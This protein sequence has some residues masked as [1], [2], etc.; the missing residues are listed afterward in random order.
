MR[1]RKYAFLR[2]FRYAGEGIWAALRT[3]RNLRVHV[4]VALLV[5]CFGWMVGL[6]R[7]EWAAIL[8]TF[9]MVIGLELV[10]TAV[11][12]LVDLASPRYHLLAKL[13]KDSAA[14]GVLVAAAA[15]VGLGLLVFLPALGNFGH[16]FMV[17]WRQS[18]SLVIAVLVVLALGY[19]VLW[20]VVPQKE[21]PEGGQNHF[22]ETH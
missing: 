19:L 21:H 9:G 17:R 3:Q 10:N 5:T 12:A 6:R 22:G 8:V 4:T 11:E 13:A 15:A 18:P 14:G 1:P 20:T 16:D 7:W 2:A